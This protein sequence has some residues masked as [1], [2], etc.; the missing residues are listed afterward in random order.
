M[1]PRT[2]PET[3]GMNARLSTSVLSGAKELRASCGVIAMPEFSAVAPS[4]PDATTCRAGVSHPESEADTGNVSLLTPTPPEW[5]TL[6]QHRAPRRNIDCLPRFTRFAKRLLDVCGGGIL[7]V[8]SLPV[9]GVAAIAIRL[10]SPGPVFFLQTRVGLN[11]RRPDN[12]VPAVSQDAASRR[13]TANYGRPF[14]IYKLRTMYHSDT[15]Q[16]PRQAVGA[17]TRVTPVG[18]FLRRTRIDELPQLVNVLKGD[19]SMVGPR[20]ECIEYMEDL[21]RQ[22]PGYLQRLGLKPGL[23]GIAQIENGYANSLHSYQRKVAYDQLYLQHCCLRNDLKI[24]LRT[25]RVVLTGFGA[26]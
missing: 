11:K 6:L 9:I 22:V 14:T 17:D 15:A 3:L 1:T 24:L 23:T 13:K 20:P 25:V 19:M 2:G 10:T 21:A 5:M 12:Q 8:L 4:P 7:L 16:G 18:R 26:L